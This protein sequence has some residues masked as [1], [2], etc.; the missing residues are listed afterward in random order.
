MARRKPRKHDGWF[1]NLLVLAA[2][3]S[4]RAQTAEAASAN[5]DPPEPPNGHAAS[6]LPAC[7][8]PAPAPYPGAP[9][10]EGDE[11][12]TGFAPALQT[13]LHPARLQAEDAAHAAP[14]LAQGERAAPVIWRGRTLGVAPLRMD[15]GR[16]SIATDAFFSRWRAHIWGRAR[17]N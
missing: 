3:L 5:I 14:A 9:W 7:A 15:D 11:A 4:A 1:A 2:A 10:F 17:S 12:R 6:G 16:V 8:T 13:T